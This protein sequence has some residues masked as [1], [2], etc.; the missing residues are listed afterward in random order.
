MKKYYFMMAAV[1]A[2]MLTACS[3]E[4]D[5]LQTGPQKVVENSAVG[6]DV[7][8]PAATQTRAGL[9]GTMTTNRLQRSEA[10]GGG[11]GVYAFLTEDENGNTGTSEAAANA[12]SYKSSTA[13]ANIPNFMVNEKILWN[14][15]NLGWYYNPLKYWPNETDKDSQSSPATME[16]ATPVHL[17]RLTFFAY[18]PYV[19]AG[20]TTGITNITDKTGKLGSKVT[21]VPM[22]SWKATTGYTDFYPN[23]GIDLLWGI[24]P[25]VDDL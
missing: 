19:T 25:A 4:D 18:A 23:E 20:S 9:V 1:S 7:Y 6:F 16:G 10:D 21:P 13:G 17:D 24:A 14:S 11:F 12:T 3:S 8:T 5:V 15:T 2:M 22:V